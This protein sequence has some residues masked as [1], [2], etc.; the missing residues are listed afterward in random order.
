MEEKYKLVYRQLEAMVSMEQDPIANMANVAALLH[1][2]FGWWWTGFI[3]WKESLVL[4]PFRDRW[5]LQDFLTGEESADSWER[6]ETIAVPD[7]DQFQVT[8]LANHF[9]EVR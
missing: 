6:R 9:P 8:S 7:V 4:G 3:V 1:E 5:P 2:T